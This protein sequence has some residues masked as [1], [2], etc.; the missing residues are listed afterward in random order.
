LRIRRGLS[1]RRCLGQSEQAEAENER[2]ESTHSVW[3]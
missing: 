3:R 1:A 2:K